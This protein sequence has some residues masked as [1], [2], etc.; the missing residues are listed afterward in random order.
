MGYTTPQITN[1]PA[2]LI[3]AERDA[4][5]SEMGIAKDSEVVKKAT[6]SNIS[7]LLT[8]ETKPELDEGVADPTGRQ[9][10]PA[11]W[12][13]SEISTVQATADSAQ[14][15]ANSAQATAND[16][17][18][19]AGGAWTSLTLVNGWTGTAK[20]RVDRW[21]Y[22]E[23]FVSLDKTGSETSDVF[24]SSLDVG[25]RFD[26]PVYSHVRMG[27][28]DE[29]IVLYINTTGV[30]VMINYDTTAVSGSAV[31]TRHLREL[32]TTP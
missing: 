32:Q 21:G 24:C 10:A 11:D 7:A 28:T 6:D 17:S 16:V 1:T 27:T 15:T 26:R 20:A 3:Q 9:L 4:W 22:L 19:N 2:E 30:C 12:V 25:L 8:F 18:V 31:Y 5:I 29:P 13:A 14:A 23:I